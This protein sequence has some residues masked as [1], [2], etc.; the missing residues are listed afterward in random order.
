MTTPNIFTQITDAEFALIKAPLLNFAVALQSPGANLEGAENAG[1][2]L[3]LQTLT[4]GNPAQV[5]AFNV[6]G[7]LLAAKI[8]GLPA[9]TT[10]TTVI[11]VPTAAVA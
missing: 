3:I 7:A 5:A 8:N 9:G 4:L 6:V 10:P 2:S 1:A 11:T